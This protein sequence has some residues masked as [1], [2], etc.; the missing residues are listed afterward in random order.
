MCDKTYQ[1]LRN[2]LDQFPLGFPETESGVEMKILQK[3]FTEEEAELELILTPIPESPDSIAK[4]TGLPENDVAVKLEDMA[5]KGLIFRTRR[6][7]QVLYNSAPF[8]VGIYEYS[9]SRVDE[10]LAHLYDQYYKEAYQ[11]EM[12]ASNVPGFRVFPVGETIK[13]DIALLPYKRIEDEIKGARKIA[14]SP[15]ICRKE[16]H[17][18]GHGC[19]HMIET[20]L[21]FGVAAEYYIE[22]GTG[23]EIDADEAIEILKKSDDQGMVHA[24]VNVTHLSNICNCCPCCCDSMKGIVSKG[25]DKIKYLNALYVAFIEQDTCTSCG[26]CEE[27]CPVSAVDV[28]DG[29]AEVDEKKCLGCGLCAGSCPEDAIDIQ[30]REKRDE[31]FDRILDLGRAILEGKEKHTGLSENQKM[32]LDLLRTMVGTR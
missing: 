20:C 29:M 24:G 2:Y 17:L 13:S 1:K 12:G 26:T 11:E 7:G 9:V 14:V 22:N 10:E 23:R 27:R 4:R 5:K 18:T 6:P 32:N 21:S 3:L 19:N 30:L 28:D 15:C 16:A 31:P 8:M 25:H